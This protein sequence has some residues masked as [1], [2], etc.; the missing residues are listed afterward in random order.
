ENCFSNETHNSGTH[1][2]EAHCTG[3]SNSEAH[4]L[5]AEIYSKKGN[6]SEAE[7]QY[8]FALELNPE[9]PKY[10]IR[11][12]NLYKDWRQKLATEAVQKYPE[13]EV[14]RRLAKEVPIN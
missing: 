10:Y 9:I 14:L 7:E 11:L 13:S 6:L 12:I 5:L 4:F 8:K 1:E 3:T 2:S